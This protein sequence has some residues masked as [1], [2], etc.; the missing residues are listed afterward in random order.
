MTQPSKGPK[1]RGLGKRARI[2]T[3]FLRKWFQSIGMSRLIKVTVINRQNIP[4]TG[5][6]I[7]APAPHASMLDIFLIWTALRRPGIAIGAEEQINK[8]VVRHVA[9]YLGQVPVKRGDAESGARARELV[10]DALRWAAAFIIYYQGKLIR[11]SERP[12]PYP[13]VADFSFESGAPVLLVY[14]HGADDIWPPKKYRDGRKRFNRKA[15]ATLIV[16]DLLYPS[17]FATREDMLVTIDNG[18]Y[19]L[20]DQL[21]Q[22]A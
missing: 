11:P 10:L 20:A 17:D 9:H 18:V 8:P 16:G 15:K 19:A 6:V 21:P 14:M 22:A 3:A 1:P 13:G 2:L 4:K 12:K 5:A 7:I